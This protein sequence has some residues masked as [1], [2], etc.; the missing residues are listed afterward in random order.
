MRKWTEGGRGEQGGSTRHWNRRVHEAEKLGAS[1]NWEMDP[2]RAVWRGRG[3]APGS[4]AGLGEG[5]ALGAG[6]EKGTRHA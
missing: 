1:M 2:E 3:S 4:Y 5:E 6:R